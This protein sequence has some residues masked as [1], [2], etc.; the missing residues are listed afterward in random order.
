MWASGARYGS[1]ALDEVTGEQV[2][3]NCAAGIVE[4]KHVD[5]FVPVVDTHMQAVA[6]ILDALSLALHGRLLFHL[7]T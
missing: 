3:V 5:L 4:L 2:E 7:G 6:P 1:L